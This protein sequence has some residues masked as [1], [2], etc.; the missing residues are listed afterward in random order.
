MNDFGDTVDMSI[1][2]QIDSILTKINGDWDSS[3]FLT[4]DT[5]KGERKGAFFVMS[6]TTC[7]HLT[8][9]RCYDKLFE[10]NYAIMSQTSKRYEEAKT[11]KKIFL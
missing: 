1:K 5:I 4:T 6:M 10:M 2:V 11:N 8:I 7:Q 9:I 3:G